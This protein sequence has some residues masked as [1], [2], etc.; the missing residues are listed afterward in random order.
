MI[1]RCTPNAISGCSPSSRIACGDHGHGVITVV[2][3]TTPSVNPRMMASFT[4]LHIP[5][6]SALMINNRASSGNPSSV[7]VWRSSVGVM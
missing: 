7:F 2:E 1:V 4:E 3:V 6:S 5:K